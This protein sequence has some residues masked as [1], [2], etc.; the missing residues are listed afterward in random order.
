M[1][2]VWGFRDKKR[3]MTFLI[4]LVLLSTFA[5]NLFFNRHSSVKVSAVEAATSIGV[6]W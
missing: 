2:G 3:L 5:V 1:V 4:V 6:Y